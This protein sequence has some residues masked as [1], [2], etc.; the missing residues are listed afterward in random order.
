MYVI[1]STLDENLWLC[2]DDYADDYFYKTAFDHRAIMS[3]TVEGLGLQYI[4]FKFSV[5]PMK[6]KLIEVN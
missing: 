4:P 1:V 5:K 2:H 6:L 3:K